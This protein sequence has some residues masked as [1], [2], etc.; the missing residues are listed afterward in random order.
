MAGMGHNQKTYVSINGLSEA[1]KKRVKDAV[2]EM[3]DSMT[4]I[5]A[6]RDLQKDTLVRMEDQL[7]IDKKMLRRMAR[8]YFKSNYAQEQDENRNF[9]EMYD[10]VMK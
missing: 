2:L 8:V 1:D 5:A 10:G 9:E 3:N 7:G 6:E 4:R